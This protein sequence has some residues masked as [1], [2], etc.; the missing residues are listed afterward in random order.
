M[1]CEDGVHSK[2]SEPT[3]GGRPAQTSHGSKVCSIKLHALL[4]SVIWPSTTLRVIQLYSSGVEAIITCQG[5]PQLQCIK[6][7][8]S[9]RT[10][11]RNS[12]PLRFKICDT[13]PGAEAVWPRLINGPTFAT[14][15]AIRPTSRNS[16]SSFSHMTTTT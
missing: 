11:H 16:F 1:I 8:F 10:E 13:R 5:S 4:F 6:E 12:L 7:K 14:R 3:Y 9:L 2:W 15:R